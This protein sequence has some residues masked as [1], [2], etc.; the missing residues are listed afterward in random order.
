MESCLS[1]LRLRCGLHSCVS[2]PWKHRQTRTPSTSAASALQTSVA[3]Q[4]LSWGSLSSS[5]LLSIAVLN[6]SFGSVFR[7]SHPVVCVRASRSILRRGS[8]RR[9]ARVTVDRPIVAVLLCVVLV[10][11]RAPGQGAEAF[12]SRGYCSSC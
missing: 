1:Q 4:S 5:T 2:R 6:V 9:K 11:R 3:V 8:R 7:R 12:R 10:W